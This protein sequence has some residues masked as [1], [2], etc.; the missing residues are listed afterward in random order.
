MPR[1]A[2]VMS[3]GIKKEVM[4]EA[5]AE[6]RVHLA[7]YRKSGMEKAIML[8]DRATGQYLSV[9]IW[10]SEDAQKNNVSSP[11]QT[12]G[13]EAMTKKYFTSPPVP[14]TFEVAAVIE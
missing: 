7:P 14:S 8:V 2:R 9:T 10:E 6:W 5:I 11:D 4:D 13:R 1:F 3:T 12:R